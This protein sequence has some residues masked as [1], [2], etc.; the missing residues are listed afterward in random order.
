MKKFIPIIL[1]CA[2]V[3]WADIAVTPGVG[4]T[5]HTDTVNSL[6]YQAV[7]IIDGTTGGTSSMTVTAAGAITVANSTIGVVGVGNFLVAN[8][9]IGVNGIGNFT[10]ANSTI[11][12]NPRVLVSSNTAL[13]TAT[14]DAG[15]VQTMGDTYGRL[16]MIAGVPTSI[17]QSTSPA[18]FSNTTA[19]V[20]VSSP[21]ATTFT[22]MCGCH[23][24]NTSTTNTYVTFFLRG[25]LTSSGSKRMMVPANNFPTGYPL[26]CATPFLD[27]RGGE[28]VAVQAAASVS[29]LYVDCKYYQSTVP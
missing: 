8:S 5:V 19:V 6:E 29:S 13:P 4:K 3:S 14:A 1:F 28:Q 17:Q 11:S 7:K 27:T 22:H 21:S 2:S 23:V 9:T 16:V 26:N 25:D 15:Q 24:G 20:L 18:A 12:V 10:I